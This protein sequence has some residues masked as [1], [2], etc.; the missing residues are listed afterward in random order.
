MKKKKSNRVKVPLYFDKVN[1]APVLAMLE[2]FRI[3]S[4]TDMTLGKFI[5]F[6]A[7]EFCLQIDKAERQRLE[8]EKEQPNE[9]NGQV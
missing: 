8:Q 4:Q 2:H 3:L 6:L 5:K 9:D 1:D 7:V